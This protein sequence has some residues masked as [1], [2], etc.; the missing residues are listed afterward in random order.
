MDRG[1]ILLSSVAKVEAALADAREV[2]LGAYILHPG[3]LMNALE[4]AARRGVRLRV[5]VEAKPYRNDGGA[6]ANLTAVARLRA[7]GVDAVAVDGLH[8]KGAVV[9][10]R[11]Y[12]DDRNWADR[13]SDTVVRDD[14][15]RDVTAAR[16]AIRGSAVRSTARLAVQKGDALEMEDRVLRGARG[17]GAVEV[18]T[19]TLSFSPQVYAT[20]AHLAKSGRHVRLLVNARELAG[21]THEANAL[22]DLAR[23]GVDV[24]SCASTEKLAVAGNHAWVGSANATYGVPAQRDWGVRTDSTAIM[25][26]LRHSFAENWKKA[27][28][29]DA[30]TGSA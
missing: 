18:A 24:R 2:T 21:N 16:D 23:D 7:L 12:L 26:H 14:D 3:G 5:R 1:M 20:L 11:L 9:D 6:K 17:G 4:D 19:E 25:R 27:K 30:S 29:F 28:E 22:H 10:D 13:G 15:R 8:F